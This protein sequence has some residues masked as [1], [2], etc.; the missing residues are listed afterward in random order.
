MERLCN[1]SSM[2]HF[3]TLDANAVVRNA[4]LT[5]QNMNRDISRHHVT[6]CHNLRGKIFIE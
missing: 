1:I 2:G 3:V 4:L 5:A 6:F